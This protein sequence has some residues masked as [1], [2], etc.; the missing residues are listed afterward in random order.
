MNLLRANAAFRRLWFARFVSFLGDSLGLVALIVYL[1]RRTDSGAVV[2]LLLLAGDM[3]PALLAPL[4]GVVAD[5]TEA[6]RTMVTCELVQAVAVGAIVV[7]QPATAL[8]LLLVAVRSVAGGVFQATS[9]SV[10]AEL[11]ADED[12]ERANTV[13]GFGTHGLEAFGALLAA[14]LLLAVTARVVLAVDVATFLVSPLLLV[15]LPRAE[16]VV[17]IGA[18]VVRDVRDGIA[19]VWRLPLVRMLA[20]TFWAFAVFTAADDV[21]LPFLGRHQFGTGDAGVSLLYAGGG[22]GIVLGLLLLG[23]RAAAP[24]AIA[25]VGLGVSGA[26]NALTGIAPAVPIA[27][28][29]Q[30]VRGVGNAWVGVGIDTLVQREAPRAVRG[31][32]FANVYGG[33]GIAA[34][35]S[36]LVGGPLVDAA[37]PRAVL[38]VG[39]AC[40]VGCAAIAAWASRSRV[41][42]TPGSPTV[43][44]P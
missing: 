9:R 33:V 44:S 14:A 19:A 37:G 5:R 4:V 35:V 22:I 30:A 34:G 3:T 29:M 36:Y 7:L 15:G 18:G 13:L 20:L 6:R 25:V 10:V 11:V 39:G 21:A 23:R 27:F 43:Q 40:G 42:R 24:F 17:D 26:G 32:V 8:I 2:G 1:S 41:T 31:R 12:L 38:G 16:V 28:F